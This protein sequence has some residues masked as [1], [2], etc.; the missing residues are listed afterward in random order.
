MKALRQ[1]W[2]S[3]D[4]KK[5]GGQAMECYCHLRNVQDL[6]AD[7]Q[8]PHERRINSPFEKPIIPFLT[9]FM[10]YPLNAGKSWTGDF[11]MVD[12]EDLK[13]MPPP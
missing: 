11:L 5:A 4:L 3:L 7:S 8:T 12:T 6:F 9:N 13:T 1:Y 10:G 2:F